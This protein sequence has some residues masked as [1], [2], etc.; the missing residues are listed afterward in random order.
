MIQSKWLRQIALGLLVALTMSAQNSPDFPVPE[1]AAPV[2]VSKALRERVNQFFQYHVGS[3]NRKAIDLVAEDTKD[4]YF[5]SGKIQ[6]IDVKVTGAVFSKDMQ[7][8]AVTLDATR[9]WQVDKYVTVA[10]TPVVTTWKLEDGK[11]V[12]YLDKQNL[13]LAATPMGT[14]APP[15][16][17][18]L[19]AQPLTNPDGTLNIPK[20][21]A[22]PAR[23]AAQGQAILNQAGVDMDSVRLT[24]GKT[25]SEQVTF[26]NGFNGQISLR[27]VGDPHIPGLKITLDR[28]DL[29]ASEDA[30]VNFTYEPPE[31]ATSG[32]VDYTL[33]LNLTPFNQEYPIRIILAAANR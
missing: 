12:F 7:R 18:K 32:N 22:E 11:W 6:F 24:S 30:H 21:F 14:S 23:V 28:V 9:N 15:P 20:D 33:R 8:A 2:D 13:D 19:A 3:V 29:G 16:T 17:G 31:G 5:S 27:L 10:T 26:H 25:S 4:F 1:S